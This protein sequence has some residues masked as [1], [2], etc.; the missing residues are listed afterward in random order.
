MEVVAGVGVDVDCDVRCDE[1]ALGEGT[2]AGEGAAVVD[3]DCETLGE[4]VVTGEAVGVGEIGVVGAALVGGGTSSDVGCVSPVHADSRNRPR[5]IANRMTAE[6]L[7]K[8]FS[9][10]TMTLFPF[11]KAVL[12]SANFYCALETP[13][14]YTPS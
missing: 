8:T 12:N 11:R 14:N 4:G 5:V 1:T 2:T 9:I 7:E 6:R 10:S 3:G 13:T